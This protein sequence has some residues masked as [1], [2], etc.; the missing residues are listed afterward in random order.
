MFVRVRDKE[1]RHEFDVH[2]SDPRIKKGI[3]ELV[4]SKKYPPVDKARRTKYFVASKGVTSTPSSAAK[5]EEE[6]END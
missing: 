2:E 1:T 3:L 6:S 4:K 5:S